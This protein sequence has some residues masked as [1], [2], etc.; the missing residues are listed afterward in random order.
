[1]LINKA[2]ECQKLTC[3]QLHK[4]AER[5]SCLLL[6][7]GQLT[8][9]DYVALVFQPGIDLIIAFYACIYVGLIPV[10]IRP[11]HLQNVQTTLPTVKMIVEMSRTKAVL[12]TG[13]TIK[14]LKSK[15]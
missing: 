14:L 12:T 7:K 2:Q 1:M 4:K 15:V 3:S 9:G 8:S 11:P 13:Q 6:D 5:V 10:P